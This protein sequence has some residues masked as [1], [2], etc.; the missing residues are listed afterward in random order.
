M[1][2]RGTHRRYANAKD[3]ELFR[4]GKSLGIFKVNEKNQQDELSELKSFVEL[5]SADQVFLVWTALNGSC[6]E[7]VEI[8]E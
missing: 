1:I 5:T 3:F 6:Y 2:S 8:C 4:N 7:E